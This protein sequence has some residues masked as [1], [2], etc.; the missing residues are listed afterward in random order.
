MKQITAYQLEDGSI[1]LTVDAA[2]RAARARHEAAMTLLHKQLVRA[3]DSHV[4]A[5]KALE[6]IEQNF[7]MIDGANDLKRDLTRIETQENDA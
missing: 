7:L 3:L 2:T 6:W 1:H 5:T 4:H